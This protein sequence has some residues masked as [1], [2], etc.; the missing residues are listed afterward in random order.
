MAAREAYSLYFFF[1]S[2]SGG[3]RGRRTRRWAPIVA[4][5]AFGKQQ[6][7]QPDQVGG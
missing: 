3:C 6:S 7:G 4:L 5:A 2:L 1:F